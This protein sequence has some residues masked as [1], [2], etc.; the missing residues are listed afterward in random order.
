M[1]IRELEGSIRASTPLSKLLKSLLNGGYEHDGGSAHKPSEGGVSGISS[2]S[3]K[4]VKSIHELLH[5]APNSATAPGDL[6]MLAFYL[7]QVR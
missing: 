7:T 5:S 4:H 6:L 2:N 1:C 3:D